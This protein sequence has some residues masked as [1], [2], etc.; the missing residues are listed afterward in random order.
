[1]EDQDRVGF[2]LW[3]EMQE[4]GKRDPHMIHAGSLGTFQR[5]IKQEPEEGLQ[6][7]WETQWQDFLKSDSGL[8]L[9]TV[10]EEEMKDFQP[11]FSSQ[12]F[13][14]STPWSRGRWVTQAL[15]GLGGESPKSYRNLDPLTTV[16]DEAEN[17]EAKRQCFRQF[18]YQE[19][20]G[21]R[22]VCDKLRELCHQWLK[23]KRR[24][25][26]Q[27]LELLILEQFLIILPLE[28]Q[29]WV[30]NCGPENCSQ[31][32]ALAEDF[33]MGQQEEKRCKQ[34][35]PAVPVAEVAV[36][37]SEADQ[38]PSDMWDRHPCR[39]AKQDQNKKGNSLDG[40]L[41]DN[42][43]LQESL[44]QVESHDASLRIGLVFQ[45][46]EEG[47][48]PFC[49]QDTVKNPGKGSENKTA[50]TVACWEGD[51]HG[52]E[53]NVQGETVQDH[54]ELK[55]HVGREGSLI[56]G[57]SLLKHQPRRDEKLLGS[58]DCRKVFLPRL[59]QL[60]QN[61]TEDRRFK[62]SEC[63][64]SFNQKRYL[65]GHKR[66]HKGETPYKCSDCGRSFNR[67]WNLIAHKRIHSGENPYKC[68]DCGKTFSQKGNLMTHTRIHTGEKP[69]KCVE[70]G[71]RFSQRAGLTSHKKSHIEINPVG[72]A[73][74]GYL[75]FLNLSESAQEGS[76]RALEGSP[77]EA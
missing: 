23:P 3:D 39:T 60:E 7:H 74:V 15:P 55:K 19:T 35:V 22:E 20:G 28:M 52:K 40:E 65:T 29:S 66:I 9:H 38:V 50:E 62:C 57:G 59:L 47:T 37:P 42:I 24:T 10:S 58:L 44:N 46:C 30:R 49:Q 73:A 1:M 61:H 18:Y 72:K 69:Y 54:M 11:S 13:V 6:Q 31:A 51:F 56:G 25:K 45:H 17:E 12:G 67:K 43:R 5:P 16:K 26:E 33:L 2:K 48:V 36:N 53:D 75:I 21:P 14:G 77:L 32:V 76:I 64:K 41:R 71:K 70:C 63:G 27:I 68:S 34:Q 8:Q 4:E